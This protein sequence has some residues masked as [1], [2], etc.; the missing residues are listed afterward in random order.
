MPNYEPQMQ[1]VS[2]LRHKSP[3]KDGADPCI[4]STLGRMAVGFLRVNS[5]GVDSKPS[6]CRYRVLLTADDICVKV[7]DQHDLRMKGRS[8]R[9]RCHFGYEKSKDRDALKRR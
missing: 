2:L 7:L 1:V 3:T 5:E 6:P 4:W 8:M 9:A